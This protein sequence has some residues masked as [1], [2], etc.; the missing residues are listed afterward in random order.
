MNDGKVTAVTVQLAPI[1][2]AI[3]DSM[4]E[5]SSLLFA[6]AEALRTGRPLLVVHVV[7]GNV[8]VAPHNLLISYETAGAVGHHLVTHAATRLKMMT[9]DKVPVE[10]LVPRGGV[11]DQLVRL[12]GTAHLVVMEQRDMTRLQRVFTGS[13]SGGV[14]GRSAVEVVMVPELWQPPEGFVN[15]VLLGVGRWRGATGLFEHAFDVADQ[16]QASLRVLHA[17]DLPSVYQDSLVDAM[18]VDQWRNDVTVQVEAAFKDAHR[19]HPGVK[20]T[21]D[22]VHDRPADALLEASR[23]ADLMVLGRREAAHPV[24]Q[25]V[26]SLTHAMLRVSECPVDVVPRPFE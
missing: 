15:R 3:G 4:E 20:A 10:T 1:V 9:E 5:D 24:V 6:S 11:V 14:A 2:V 21:V 25:H 8:P 16:H 17:W 19:H 7:H 13:V 18:A 26:G 12:S 22:V 23:E